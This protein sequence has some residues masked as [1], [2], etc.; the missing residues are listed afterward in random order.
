[1]NTKPTS[2][3]PGALARHC[4]TF[5]GS[6]SEF[7]GI[8]IV[9]VLLS[10][11]TLG[12]YSAWAKVRTMNYFY[13]NTTLGGSSFAYTA[14][15]VAILKGRLIAFAL[16]VPYLLLSETSPPLALTFMLALFLLA[17]VILVRSLRFRLRNT[18]Y[19][20]LR[21]GFTGTTGE[22]YGIF[23]GGFLLVMLSLGIL[24]PWL[25]KRR[26]EYYVGNARFGDSPFACAPQLGHFYKCAGVCL[27][28]PLSFG[29]LF[30]GASWA[31][32]PESSFF[33]GIFAGMLFYPVLGCLGAYWFA[34][35]TN[36]VL[37]RSRLEDIRFESC[38]TTG[39]LLGL[40]VVNFLLLA[41]S[42]GLATPWVM[43][44]NARYRASCTTVIAANLDSFVAGKIE[45]SSALGEEMGEAFEVDLA[46]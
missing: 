7:F 38:L 27:L 42:F 40:W 25:E 9:N 33:M 30:V 19:R 35:T 15:P 14:D 18:E 3:A 22:A 43:V 36:H 29:L 39:G 6:G 11:C 16:L 31:L 2:T 46:I 24:F 44:R 5:N 20:G 23:V 1:M 28:V 26:K 13:G 10:I 17:P 12:I 21:F 41:F 4:L 45:T 37:A 32:P 8:W 34:E